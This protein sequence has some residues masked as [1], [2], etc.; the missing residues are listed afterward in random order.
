MEFIIGT[1]LA[2]IPIVLEAYDRYWQMSEAFSTF[3]HSSTEL[4][5]IETTLKPQKTLF[6][7][8]ALDLL[9]VITN[10]PAM[11]QD[12]LSTSNS[13]GWMK[14]K[15]DDIF[16]GRVESLQEAF[17]SWMA[18]AMQIKL[19]LTS[20]CRNLDGWRDKTTEE[21]DS[22]QESG[23]RVTRREVL[24]RFNLA[25]RKPEILKSIKEL[26]EFTADFSE[27]TRRLVGDL[28]NISA[29]SPLK[30]YREI[31]NASRHL[32]SMF[33]GNWSCNCQA[34]HLVS[35]CLNQSKSDD[36]QPRPINFNVAVAAVID[37]PR[38]KPLWL[39]VEL[40]DDS[41]QLQNPRRTHSSEWIAMI[42]GYS[43]SFKLPQEQSKTRK[44][45]RKIPKMP[46]MKVLG[47]QPPLTD[48]QKETHVD[49]SPIIAPVREIGQIGDSCVY[50]K[51]TAP[52]SIA[53]CICE[54]DTGS[55]DRY[56]LLVRPTN[57]HIGGRPIT[58][59]EII[60]CASQDDITRWISRASLLHIAA[61]LAS[62]FLQFYST[63]WMP[64]RWE[65]SD[66]R[67]FGAGIEH[68]DQIDLIKSSVYLKMRLD[69]ENLKS[70]S[71]LYGLVRN[72]L[73]FQLGIILLE[74]GFSK[75]WQ[76]LRDT[77][78]PKL[79]AKTRTDY[80]AAEKLTKSC[81]LRERLRPGYP[82]VVRKFLGCDFGLGE[83][84]F[85]NEELQ[86][87]FLSDVVMT[88][89]KAE[90]ELQELGSRLRDMSQSRN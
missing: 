28:S 47:S 13:P 44:K 61:E 32:Y 2:G 19:C 66:I 86:G 10:N 50:F 60:S 87:S 24:K 22:S 36:L 45:L 14:L 25:W 82:V 56:Y 31:R 69:S 3:R 51:I 73:L 15:M 40:V 75:P 65:S 1:V 70:D 57:Q 39:N 17:C 72:E 30:R 67:L 35:V 41:P 5:K 63:P 21:I 27:L 23:S 53:T 52:D 85:E 81:H 83:S 68:D 55:T 54:G 89:R 18:T 16:A 33:A 59:S 78:L 26:Q 74:L 6:R 37:R 71:S 42:E 77:I 34:S 43:S 29:N 11:A 84:D 49:A 48:R 88:L 76:E 38:M 9:T 7:R 20:L 4:M 62:A 64:E 46:E 90:L 79:P 12:L 8:N 80:H 58:L